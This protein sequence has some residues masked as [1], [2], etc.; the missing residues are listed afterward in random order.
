M[1]TLC[2]CHVGGHYLCHHA[3]ANAMQAAAYPLTG[4][5]DLKYFEC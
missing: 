5:C 1:K 3:I 2:Y 4:L